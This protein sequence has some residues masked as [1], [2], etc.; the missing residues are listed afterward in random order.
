MTKFIHLPQLQHLQ[1]TVND[2][3]EN[4]QRKGF[5]QPLAHHAHHLLPQPHSLFLAIRV[6]VGGPVEAMQLIVQVTLESH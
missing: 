2:Q 6:P 5:L 4:P 3:R 1:K